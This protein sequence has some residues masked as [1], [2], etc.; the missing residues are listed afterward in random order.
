MNPMTNWRSKTKSISWSGIFSVDSLN[1]HDGI[2]NES[3]NISFFC[4]NSLWTSSCR[5]LSL[6]FYGTHCTAELV[7]ESEIQSGQG[8]GPLWIIWW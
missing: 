2:N 6:M 1:Y 5:L 7:K 4:L 3:K 8:P